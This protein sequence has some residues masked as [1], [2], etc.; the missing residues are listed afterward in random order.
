MYPARRPACDPMPMPASL[1]VESCVFRRSPSEM[2]DGDGVGRGWVAVVWLG[3]DRDKR[4]EF[5]SEERLLSLASGNEGKAR[6]GILLNAT[7]YARVW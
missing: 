3:R 4:V 2:G 7:C 1:A 5:G 6:M